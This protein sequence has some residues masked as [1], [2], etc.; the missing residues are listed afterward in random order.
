MEEVLETRVGGF[1]L[2]MRNSSSVK[3]TRRAWEQK[4]EFD[5]TYDV[6]QT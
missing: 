4:H 5:T 3:K 1:V 2:L 6:S